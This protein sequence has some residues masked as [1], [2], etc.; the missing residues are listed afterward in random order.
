MLSGA[1]SDPKSLE[2]I[3]QQPVL[4][5]HNIMMRPL[6]ARQKKRRAQKPPGFFSSLLPSQNTHTPNVVVRMSPTTTRKLIETTQQDPRPRRSRGHEKRFEELWIV[7]QVSTLKTDFFPFLK[8]SKL[9][10]H[11]QEIFI[12]N[13]Y[14]FVKKDSHHLT[15]LCDYL[16]YTIY[17][18]NYLDVWSFFPIVLPVPT[19]LR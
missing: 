13:L 15:T 5:S 17:H 3:W 16:Y 2:T 18:H 10:F 8:K 1:L 19:N 7:Y 4:P 14:F 6:G 12:H 9:S 11:Q